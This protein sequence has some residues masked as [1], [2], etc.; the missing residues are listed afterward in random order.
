MCRQLPC[1]FTQTVC[2]RKAPPI[3][4]C[5]PFPTAPI[6]SKVYAGARVNSST[7]Q[8]Q[9]SQEIL[10]LD[11]RQRDDTPVPA[12]CAGSQGDCVRQHPGHS[13]ASRNSKH[14]SCDSLLPLPTLFAH[15]ATR[16]PWSN[17]RG[18]P[19][20]LTSRIT[21]ETQDLSV[22]GALLPVPRH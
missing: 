16:C 10:R 22:Y 21:V 6:P 15:M 17:L 4:H 9:K 19:T 18:L 3:L 13:R 8:R 5:Q 7:S 20:I 11:R 14:A 1:A 2:V 12:W